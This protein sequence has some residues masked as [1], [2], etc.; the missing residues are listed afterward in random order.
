MDSL[1]RYYS[2]KITDGQTAAYMKLNAGPMSNIKGPFEAELI[3]AA[4]APYNWEIVEGSARA[5]Y[6]KH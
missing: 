1:E 5:V 2:V 6:I 3:A 4:L